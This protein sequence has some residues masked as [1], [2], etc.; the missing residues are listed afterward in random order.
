MKF[1]LC[2]PNFGGKVGPGELLELAVAAEV[3]GFDSVWATDHIIMPRRLKSPYDELFEPF[4]TLASIA[5]KTSGVKLGTSVLVL[6]Q[7]DPFLVAKQAATLDQFSGGRMILGVGAG[8]AEGEFEYLRADFRKRGKVL[9][10]GIDLLR[11]LW[12]DSTIN[13]SGKFFRVSSDAAFF[14]KPVQKIIPIWVGG[15]SDAAIE[16]AAKV[17]D[18]WHPVGVDPGRL[19]QGAGRVKKAGTEKTISVRLTV[20]VKRR[21]ED[22]VSADGEK[23]VTLSGSR[24]EMSRKLDEYAKAGLEYLVAYIYR[25][26]VREMVADIAKFSGEIIRSYS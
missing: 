11:R 2:L 13:Y 18:G 4:V 17:G 23:R 6:P 9:D 19:S 15:T 3:N 7:R 26:E 16:R 20:E 14:P 10:E 22:Y 12:T 1:G 24:E 21:R 5:A 8:W 25:D